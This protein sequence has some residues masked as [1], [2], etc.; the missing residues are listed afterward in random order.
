MKTVFQAK[1]WNH[2]RWCH[3]ELPKFW[4]IKRIYI[5]IM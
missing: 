1:T 2:Y 4:D 3:L 5:P